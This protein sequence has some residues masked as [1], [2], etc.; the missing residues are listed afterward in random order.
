MKLEIVAAVLCLAVARTATSSLAQ[1]TRHNLPGRAAIFLPRMRNG[2]NSKVMQKEAT[3]VEIIKK[4]SKGVEGKDVTALLADLK[5]ALAEVTNY[6]E[7]VFNDLD[8]ENPSEVRQKDRLPKE[9]KSKYNIEQH[10]FSLDDD[11]NAKQSPI[12]NIQ[13]PQQQ[14]Y[15]QQPKQFNNNQQQYNNLQ[16]QQYF[17]QRQQQQQFN[18]QPYAQEQPVPRQIVTGR[19]ENAALFNQFGDA[20]GPDASTDPEANKYP[21]QPQLN[22][23]QQEAAT[24]EK[25]EDVRCVKKLM[26]VE[27]TVYEEKVKCQHTFSE[28]CHDT[29]IT[30][31]VPTQEKKCETSFS[32]NCH[33]TYKPM[34]FEEDV[35]ICNEPLTKTCNNNT[36]GQGEI[37]CNTHYETICETRYKEH[38]V[39]Q[40]EPVCE[41]V[42]E[43]K[44][45][46][47]TIPVPNI[48]FRRRRQ[49]DDLDAADGAPAL[50][51]GELGPDVD[52]DLAA[53]SDSLVSIGEEC[54][55]WPVQKCTLQEKKVKK[56]TPDTACEK[57]PKEICAPGNCVVGVSE[58][59]CR[60]ETRALLQNIPTEECDLEPQE[61]CKMETVL[62]PR[63]VQQPNCI[64]V[65]K[66]VCVNERVNPKK[67]S[68]PVVKEWCYK[69]S[70]LKEPTSR[71]A[72]SQF[73]KKTQ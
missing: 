18:R 48:Q 38:E 61:N 13:Q 21:S 72:L 49:A 47:V 46:E 70:D 55:E 43:K 44:C 2:R 56:T 26:Q 41:M 35:E 15:N 68:R 14:F 29:F 11:L 58:K 63:L 52:L 31:Y 27:E 28:K 1:Y 22:P 8:E 6:D 40:D 25:K 7:E 62:V 59:K 69:P 60:T 12:V 17:Q 67:V 3:P 5:E 23:R 66:E 65:P 51:S 54:E 37:V 32:K 34:M 19:G 20:M 24:E 73:F 57:I 33:I 45:K 36:I 10:N 50:T 71:L 53:E 9:N 42:I 4:E 16:Q 64:K 30:D 39:T